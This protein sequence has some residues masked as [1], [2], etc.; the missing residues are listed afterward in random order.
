MNPARGANLPFIQYSL[1]LFV[2]K[3]STFFKVLGV[4]PLYSVQTAIARYYRNVGDLLG[5]FLVITYFR[6]PMLATSNRF[7]ISKG[8]IL[9]H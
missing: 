4:L 1:F 7:C 9:C 2:L 3:K 8:G 6:S 5:L